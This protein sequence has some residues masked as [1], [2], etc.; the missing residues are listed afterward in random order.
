[1]VGNIFIFFASNFKSKRTE[2][3]Q[4]CGMLAFDANYFGWAKQQQ[5]KMETHATVRMHDIV[6]T[7]CVQARLRIYFRSVSR[8]KFEHNN[9]RVDKWSKDIY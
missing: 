9:D 3:Y 4:T 8:D 5:Q 7:Q 1:M 2:M 6:Y